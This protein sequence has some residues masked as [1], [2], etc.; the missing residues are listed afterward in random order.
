[1]TELAT[2]DYPKEYPSDAVRIL[3]AMSFGDGLMLVGSMSLK[4]QQYAGDFDGYEIVQTKGSKDAAL[5]KLKLRFQAMIRELQKMKNVFIGDIKAGS[6]VEWRVL[7]NPV[8]LIDGKVVGY[9]PKYSR[10]VL[11]N[12]P[13]LTDDQR[14]QGRK[15]L[16]D[17]MSPKVY[18][19]AKDFFKFNTVRWK[20]HEVLKGSKELKDGRTFTLEEAFST[21]GIAKMDTI[22]L[23]QN[24]RFTDF[25]VIYEFRNNGKVLNPEPLKI[26]ESLK[27]NILGLR[28]ESNYFKMIKRMFALAKLEHD[29]KLTDLLTPFLN[30]D[31]GRVYQLMGDIGTIL[32][33]LEGAPKAPMDVIR[34]EIDQFKARLANI[35]TFDDFL[36]KEP[37]IIKTIEHSLTQSKEKLIPS[38]EK[39]KAYL[40]QVLQKHSYDFLKTHRLTAF[41]P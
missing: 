24:N 12:I 6:I 38:L 16:P 25:S 2:K 29:T 33:V 21:P 8:K 3:N 20:P 40:N 30:A 36:N 17:E 28:M 5:H 7:P 23:V 10:A 27:E 32:D 11:K 9:D 4:S 1:M 14:A 41:N 18:F 31:A 35:Y 19:A 13:F 15:L 22:G 37:S 26:S 34:Y 39:V